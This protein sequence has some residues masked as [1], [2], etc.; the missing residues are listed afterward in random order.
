MSRTEIRYSRSRLLGWI[1]MGLPLCLLILA[2]AWGVSDHQLMRFRI[3]RLFGPDPVRWFLTAGGL[4]FLA[5][6]LGAMRRLS[7]SRPLAA[8]R[9][10]GLELNGLFMSRHIPWRS[11]DAHSPDAPRPAR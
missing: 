10:D 5:G 8:I 6:V 2:V 11:L 7:G 1:L 9:Y 4:F 3:L